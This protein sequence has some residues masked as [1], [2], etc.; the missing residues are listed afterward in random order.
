MIRI[1]LR[2]SNTFIKLR[3]EFL[4]SELGIHIV[5][6]CQ[7][8]QE[9]LLRVQSLI[10]NNT[11]PSSRLWSLREAKLWTKDNI[12]NIRTFCRD[13]RGLG[14][15]QPVSFILDGGKEN[16]KIIDMDTNTVVVETDSDILHVK[17]ASS[18]KLMKE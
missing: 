5:L 11:D 7:I 12:Y 14:I 18:Y 17:M 8:R 10:F 9:H 13:I 4:G 1:K 6:G 2:K 3:E 15:G 16:G